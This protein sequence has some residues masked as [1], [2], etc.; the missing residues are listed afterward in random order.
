M[1]TSSTQKPVRAA[2]LIGALM[3]PVA[4]SAIGCAGGGLF[5]PGPSGTVVARLVGTTAVLNY[6]TPASPLPVTNAFAVQLSEA[7]YYAQFNA[8]IISY[9]A[10]TTSACYMVTMD[11][12]GTIAS[13]TP[14]N[15]SSIGPLPTPTPPAIPSAT[16]TP[17]G[18]PGPTPTPSPSPG[19]STA[20][21]PCFAYPDVEGVRF[22]DQQNHTDIQYF[23]NF[24]LTTI[25]PA[26]RSK[27]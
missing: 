25:A 10:P 18:T 3:V 23:E 27:Q 7:H 21:G 20:P 16:P 8:S 4:V 11:S 26:A 1:S 2:R 19:P 22:S 14:V 6:H 15:A 13:F 17:A 12:T 24:P 5:Q 9:T